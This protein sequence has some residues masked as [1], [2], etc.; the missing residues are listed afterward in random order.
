MPLMNSR[1]PHT[2]D[3]P[4]HGILLRRKARLLQAPRK[5]WHPLL[6]RKH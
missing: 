3:P 2:P 1:T 5:L 6:Q 4:L